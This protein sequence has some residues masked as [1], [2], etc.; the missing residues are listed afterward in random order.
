MTQC[1]TYDVPL[2][3]IVEI[4]QEKLI[5]SGPK[6]KYLGVRVNYQIKICI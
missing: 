2:L 4:W 3:I 1:S 5:M 6:S